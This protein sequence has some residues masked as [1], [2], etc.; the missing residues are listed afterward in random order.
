MTLKLLTSWSP[1]SAMGLC[2]PFAIA[3]EGGA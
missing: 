2:Q 1:R 3:S